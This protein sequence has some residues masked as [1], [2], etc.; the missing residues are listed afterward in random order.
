MEL[1]FDFAQDDSTTG[2][3]L[4][5]FE[6]YNW[7]T[8]DKQVVSLKLDKQNGLL[9]GDIGSGKSTIVDALTTLLVPHQKITFN[10]AA[11]AESKERTLKSYILGEYKSA[12]DESLRNAK[13]VALRDESSFTVLL[14]KFFNDGYDESFTVAQFFYIA[15]KQVQSQKREH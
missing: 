1:R 4:E 3:R 2:F 8:Y 12:Q 9:T 5:E 10:K 15:N 11:G 13:A 7:G 6:L 14:A